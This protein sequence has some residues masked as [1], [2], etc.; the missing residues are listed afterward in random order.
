MT[1]EVCSG[2][3]RPSDVLWGQVAFDNYVN[4]VSLSYISP[5]KCEIKSQLWKDFHPV[6]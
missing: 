1:S 3:A 5:L 6:I 2:T 4:Y